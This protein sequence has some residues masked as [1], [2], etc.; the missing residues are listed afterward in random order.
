MQRNQCTTFIR[1][2][3]KTD[4]KYIP[5]IAK[6][7]KKAFPNF[8]LT[9][10]GDAF[11]R[12]LYTGYL[13]DEASGIFIAEE[14]GTLVGFVAFSM[15]Y[16]KFYRELIR[17]HLIKFAICSLGA[18]IRHPSFIKRLFGA[19]GKSRAVS[20]SESYVEL[21]SICVSPTQKRGGIGS[22][23]VE[24]LKDRVDF[25][26]YAFIN[27]ETDA[28]KNEAVNQFYHKNGFHLACQYITKE[29]RRMNEYRY[30]PGEL[31]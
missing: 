15:D 14:S 19:F 16:P 28:D 7:H 9:K 3:N 20:K 13:E 27:L 12:A 8:F 25:S 5:E 24:Y 4:G 2:L 10:L 26:K 21:A 17:N 6:L 11:I 30:S 22:S 1:Q 31:M 29:G 18:A 23:L